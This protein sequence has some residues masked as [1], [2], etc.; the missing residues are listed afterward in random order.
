MDFFFFKNLSRKSRWTPC[1]SLE[2]EKKTVLKILNICKNSVFIFFQAQSTTKIP[3]LAN[4]DSSDSKKGDLAPTDP[5]PDVQYK[6]FLIKD[7]KAED[8]EMETPVAAYFTLIVGSTVCFCVCFIFCC[9]IKNQ[10]KRGRKRN[11]A[12][13]AGDAGDYLVN[14]LYL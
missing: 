4:K 3:R 1:F 14:G 2:C 10:K 7:L 13:D 6:N 9:R 8:F 11:L 12:S 5:D